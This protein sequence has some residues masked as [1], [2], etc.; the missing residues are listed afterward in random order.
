MRLL[1]VPDYWNYLPKLFTEARIA[2]G[3][4]NKE[5]AG[6][7]HTSEASSS[8]L[9]ADNRQSDLDRL[10]FQAAPI[11]GVAGVEPIIGVALKKIH[12]DASE[13]IDPSLITAADEFFERIRSAT[14]DGW[15]VMLEEIL[16]AQGFT[17]CEVA[18]RLD[19]FLQRF[20]NMPHACE[21]AVVVYAMHLGDGPDKQEAADLMDRAIC[22]ALPFPLKINALLSLG[23]LLIEMGR[24]S[25]G[26]AVLADVLAYEEE[27]NLTHLQRGFGKLFLAEVRMFF[28]RH[29]KI[30][31]AMIRS[32]LQE[33]IAHLGQ[34]PKGKHRDFWI[35]RANALIGV[36]DQDLS[37]INGAVTWLKKLMVPGPEG[38]RVRTNLGVVLAL[39]AWHAKRAGDDEL[40]D[41]SAQEALRYLNSSAYS[42][43]PQP[44]I[45]ALLDP[46]RAQHFGFVLRSIFTLVLA[47]LS[48]VAAAVPA[49]AETCH[50]PFAN[51]QASH[52]T[53]IT[54]EFC[55]NEETCH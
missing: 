14:D 49:H 30:D 3:L 46:P 37:Q 11:L 44:Q 35:A 10:P 15:V 32:M 51:I 13:D 31:K 29:P 48:F 39:R 16:E 21:Y 27:W 20:G 33:S 41:S 50:R 5:L 9:T 40:A 45:V 23:Q 28:A 4:N 17:R 47:A 52:T 8:R 24:F 53:E 22:E 43:N 6:L 25:E 36:I 34:L 7:L 2:L 54:T 55:R 26:A 12:R 18:R 42:A 19:A 1:P 38:R